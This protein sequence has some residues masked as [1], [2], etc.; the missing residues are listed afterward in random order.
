MATEKQDDVVQRT[1]DFYTGTTAYN[2]LCYVVRQIISEMVNT[3]ALVSVNSVEAAGHENAAGNLSATPLVAQTD[4]R[5]NKLPMTQIPKL[6]FFRYQAGKAAIVLDPVA[7]DQGVAVFFKQD[8]SGVKGGATEAVVPGSFRAFDQSDGVVFPSVQGAAPSVWIELKQD[9]TITIH[10]PQGVKIETDK[11]VEVEA[12]VK[13]KMTAPAI[14]LNGAISTASASGDAGTMSIK[15]TVN[16]TQD[17]KASNIS[18]NSHT[19]TCPDGE[20]SGPH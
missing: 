5:G 1:G 20:T 12:G 2:Q 15:G 19:H 7:G 9:E 11:N 3:S 13:I 8:S 17:V 4:A 14:E 16:V 18:L 6:R 10:A